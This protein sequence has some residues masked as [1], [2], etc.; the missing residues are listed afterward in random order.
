MKE[1]PDS[2]DFRGFRVLGKYYGYNNLLSTVIICRTKG[3][4]YV[5]MNAENSNVIIDN[6]LNLSKY[7]YSGKYEN[8]S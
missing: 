1:L 6:G 4:S 5:G 8:N 7:L 2:L 3:I